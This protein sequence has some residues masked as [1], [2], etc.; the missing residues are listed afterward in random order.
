MPMLL[1]RKVLVG[2]GWSHRTCRPTC[3]LLLL[4]GRRLLLLL[5]LAKGA[6]AARNGPNHLPHSGLHVLSEFD[7]YEKEAS[8]ADAHYSDG[9]QI[10]PFPPS[11]VDLVVLFQ[12]VPAGD[13]R[14]HYLAID[15]DI[16]EL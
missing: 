16:G 6:H 13:G 5:L 3:H 10:H 14:S 1:E 11:Q 2:R 12:H 8:V 4:R 15:F 9:T 7:D